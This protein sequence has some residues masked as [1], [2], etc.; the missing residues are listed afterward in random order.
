M[1]GLL[2]DG[3]RYIYL[4]KQGIW[5]HSTSILTEE[6]PSEGDRESERDHRRPGRKE[7]S[8]CLYA[9]GNHWCYHLACLP[10]FMLW[11]LLLR[12]VAP[13]ATYAKLN[14]C[15]TR[16]VLCRRR[17]PEWVDHRGRKTLTATKKETKF[18]IFFMNG[19]VKPTA[20]GEGSTQLQSRCVKKNQGRRHA[21]GWTRRCLTVWGRCGGGKEEGKKTEEK[22]RASVNIQ[23]GYIRNIGE[24]R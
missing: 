1:R 10:F 16:K 23:K 2:N 5:V 4:K 24:Q 19:V 13:L 17:D 14:A 7:H 8:P 3:A 18:D 21:R 11:M 12:P 20:P 22:K 9:G 15:A 6:N